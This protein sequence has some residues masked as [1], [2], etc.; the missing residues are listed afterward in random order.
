MLTFD[1]DQFIVANSFLGNFVRSSEIRRLK[2]I[3]ALH[4]GHLSAESRALEVDRM[5][6]VENYFNTEQK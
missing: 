6:C 2:H 4:V 5:F 1:Q 3:F